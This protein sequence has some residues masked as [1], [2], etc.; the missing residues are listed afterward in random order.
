M[1]RVSSDY[2]TSG[3]ISNAKSLSETKFTAGVFRLLDDDLI[4][5][6]PR[7]GGDEFQMLSHRSY[8]GLIYLGNY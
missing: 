1:L 2:S 3:G 4:G 7:K 8:W 6:F 5:I